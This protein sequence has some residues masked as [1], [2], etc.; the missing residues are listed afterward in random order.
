MDKQTKKLRFDIKG[1]ER[2]LDCM[3]T[4]PATVS[5]ETY[6]ER[7][8]TRREVKVQFATSDGIAPIDFILNRYSSKRTDNPSY[9]MTI[10]YGENPA[11]NYS[12]EAAYGVAGSAAELS[13]IATLFN[14]FKQNSLGEIVIGTSEKI[15]FITDLKKVLYN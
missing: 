9:S 4:T 10:N 6:L 3:A 5:V 12:E 2:L 15:G 14:R 7:D 1:L 13:S 11:A 8:V